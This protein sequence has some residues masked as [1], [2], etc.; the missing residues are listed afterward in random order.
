METSLPI[1]LVTSTLSNSVPICGSSFHLVS[2]LRLSRS[3]WAAGAGLWLF[4]AYL[5]YPPLSLTMLLHLS[6][7]LLLDSKGQLLRIQSW[8][9]F[10]FFPFPSFS[11]LDSQLIQKISEL[12]SPKQFDHYVCLFTGWNVRGEWVSVAWGRKECVV[13]GRCQWRAGWQE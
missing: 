9:P 4:P 1:L 11:K 13:L 10:K 5:V 2:Q 7:S 3:V 8:A 6:V 12:D